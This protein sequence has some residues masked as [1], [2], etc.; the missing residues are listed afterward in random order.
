MLG[1]SL[2]IM[3]MGLRTWPMGEPLGANC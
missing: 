1:K 3:E 2:S